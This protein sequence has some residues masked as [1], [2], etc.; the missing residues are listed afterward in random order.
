MSRMLQARSSPEVIAAM[1][2]G[3]RDLPEHRRSV[4]AIADGGADAARA[5]LRDLPAMAPRA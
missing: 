4:A 5:A 1:L 3:D 2:A